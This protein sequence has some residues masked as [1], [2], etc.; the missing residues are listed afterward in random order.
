MTRSTGAMTE[1]AHP[2]WPYFAAWLIAVVGTFV[3]WQLYL[4]PLKALPARLVIGA[5]N[6]YKFAY[7]KFRVDEAYEY[8]IIR[9]LKYVARCSGGWWTSSPSTASS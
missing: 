7:E 3:A 5:P 4:G 9:P 6:L 1:A 2:S 8:L